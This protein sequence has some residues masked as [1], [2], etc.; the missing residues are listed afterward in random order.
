MKKTGGRKSRDT[1]PLSQSLYDIY[2]KQFIIVPF[3]PQIYLEIFPNQSSPASAVKGDS[4]QPAST[5]S[6]L[7]TERTADRKCMLSKC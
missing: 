2:F 1:L 5:P 3:S 6:K 7:T 4:Q